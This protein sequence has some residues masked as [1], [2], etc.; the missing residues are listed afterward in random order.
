M[1]Q[2]KG[3]REENAVKTPLGT[4]LMLL[5]LG[6][7]AAQAQ[8]TAAAALPRWDFAAHVDVYS[9][10]HDTQ[11]P[12]CDHWSHV[13]AG[14]A[15]LGFYWAPNV[16]TEVDL[17]TSDEGDH[18][19]TIQ[20]PTPGTSFPPYRVGRR[21]YRDTTLSATQVYQ[22]FRNE[23]FHPTLGV[24]VDAQWAR[25]HGAFDPL[26]IYRRDRRVSEVIE[27]ARLEP[28]ETNFRAQ[29]FV[30]TGFKAYFTERAFF[31]MDL[32]FVLRDQTRQTSW[33]S[34]F[35]IDF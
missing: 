31:R 25:T 1:H 4:L 14:G 18:Y 24:G 3:N 9:S 27:P 30:V 8:T 7:A 32:K 34:G 23:W 6:G 12:C 22:F 21:Y 33:R 26:T 28:S 15:G 2:Q 19:V 11:A 13:G 29:P 16:K 5:V 10:R 17:S 20:V 35:G